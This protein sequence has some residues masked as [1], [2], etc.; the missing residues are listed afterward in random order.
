MDLLTLVIILIINLLSF[1]IGARIGQKVANN[2][3]I[4]VNPAIA[5]H[6]AIQEVQEAKQEQKET[7][8]KVEEDEY[9][10]TIYHNIDVY[11]GTSVGQ[12]PV[13]IINVRE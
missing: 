9:F 13:P 10:K 6:E 7:K 8:A 2:E 3:R 4:E 1:V 12:K 11:D 5:L